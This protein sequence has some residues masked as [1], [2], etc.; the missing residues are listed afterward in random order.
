MSP[1]WVWIVAI[2]LKWS[3]GGRKQGIFGR[4]ELKEWWCQAGGV[5]SDGCK[6]KTTG[7]P[8]ANVEKMQHSAKRVGYVLPSAA[9]LEWCDAV[10]AVFC[11][12][13]V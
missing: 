11:F 4:N 7:F 1:G 8:L 13:D 5:F 9:D 10:M 6:Q 3:T 2:R 12:E